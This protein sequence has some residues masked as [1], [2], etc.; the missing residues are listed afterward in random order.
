MGAEASKKSK[1]WNCCNSEL[2]WRSEIHTTPLLKAHY[3]ICLCSF[4]MELW[5]LR[6]L[7]AS[8]ITLSGFMIEGASMSDRKFRSSPATLARSYRRLVYAICSMTRGC[9]LG[10]FP[11]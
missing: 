10:K 11:N 7:N 6:R 2:D 8:A 1:H 9:L 3:N 4:K 5:Q